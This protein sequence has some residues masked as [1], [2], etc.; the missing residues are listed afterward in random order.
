MLSAGGRLRWRRAAC[1]PPRPSS[2]LRRLIALRRTARLISSAWRG[3]SSFGGSGLLSIRPDWYA[4]SARKY[5]I[6]GRGVPR[7]TVG[8]AS[9]FSVSVLCESWAVIASVTASAMSTFHRERLGA[10][11]V[12]ALNAK[13]S[14]AVRIRDRL[15][16]YPALRRGESDALGLHDFLLAPRTCGRRGLRAIPGP[17]CASHS[18][19]RSSGRPLRLIAT[20]SVGRPHTEQPTRL[21]VRSCRCSGGI[22]R[23]HFSASRLG[24]EDALN[25]AHQF[26]VAR[27]PPDGVAQHLAHLRDA[28]VFGRGRLGLSVAV[29]PAA[30]ACAIG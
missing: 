5:D 11:V 9:S 26:P 7:G 30:D 17:P 21:P 13:T 16:Q 14:G 6:S 25:L 4:D 3:E 23:T 19:I 2:I 10:L 28:R 27:E 24:A 18:A 8:H 29:A 22:H 15:C 20:M 12:M 1:H